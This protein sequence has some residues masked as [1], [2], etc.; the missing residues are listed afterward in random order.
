MKHYAKYYSAVMLFCGIISVL[1][2]CSEEDGFKTLSLGNTT[3]DYSI[4]Q[5]EVLDIPVD[6]KN[7]GKGDL[8]ATVQCSDADYQVKVGPIEN[9]QAHI[10]L[11]APEY[12]L[13]NDPFTVD[14]AITDAKSDRTLSQQFNLTPIMASNMVVLTAPANSFIV[15]EG[16]IVA[17][18]ANI[19]NSE[20]VASIDSVGLVWQDNSGLVTKLAVAG[21]YIVA[22]L[23]ADKKGNALV[24]GY[25]NAETVWD[26]HLW[27]NAYDPNEKT[28]TY[29]SSV[30]SDQATYVF[31]DRNM[32]AMSG[33]KSTDAFGLFY[34]WG[35]KEPIAHKTLYDIDGNEVAMTVA[36][37]KD[38][39][40]AAGVS[41]IF[42]Y[43]TK[44]P[45]TFFSGSGNS[46]GNYGWFLTDKTLLTNHAEAWGTKEKKS[47]NDPCPAGWRIPPYTAYAFYTDATSEDGIVRE[48]AYDENGEANA[49]KMGRLVSTDGGKTKI[50]FPSQGEFNN[51]GSF[52]Y[53][54][55]GTATYPCGKMWT[56]DAD[57]TYYRAHNINVSPTMASITGGVV[58]AYGIAVRCVKE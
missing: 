56:R 26:W 48:F 9:G 45:F 49:N 29:T 16:S 27:V 42:E 38:V 3:F 54:Y 17:F 11:T 24:A 43:G 34:Q 21:N 23:S 12:I 14:F 52:S 4:N 37:A 33:E 18:P 19:G 40:S 51:T 2:S 50:F 36:A 31:M 28:M 20:E 58:T 1:P 7:V 25:K 10:E 13:K 30:E 53:A 6:I 46:S 15:S 39:A 57:L 22:E 41:D 5:G 8:T 35:R 32:G 47:V 55:D 44:N